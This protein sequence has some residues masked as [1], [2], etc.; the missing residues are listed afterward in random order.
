[1]MRNLLLIPAFFLLVAS[2]SAQRFG[3]GL[4][5]GLSATQVSGDN[6]GGFDKAGI[7][8]GGFVNLK[9]SEKFSAQ[10]ELMFIQKGSKSNSND[11]IFYRMKLQYVEVPILIGYHYKKFIF[12]AGP[13]V[14]FLVSATEEDFYSVLKDQKPFNPI[15]LSVNIGITYPLLNRLY[16][17]WRISNSVIPIREHASGATFRLNRGQYNSMLFFSFRYYFEKK[18]K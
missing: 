10:M 11:S 16:L 7:G 2:V 4:I 14:G 13:S 5:A 12:D 17:N 3:G 15:D 9:F 1:M 6:L 18:E 8:A